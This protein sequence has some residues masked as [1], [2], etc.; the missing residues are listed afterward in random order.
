[1]AA[2]SFGVYEFVSQQMKQQL[3]EDDER[4][5]DKGSS[6]HSDAPSCCRAEDNVGTSPIARGCLRG[7]TDD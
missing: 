2:V 7:E 3:G 1:M 5:I 6:A 4:G